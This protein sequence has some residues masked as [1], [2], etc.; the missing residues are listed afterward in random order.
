MHVRIPSDSLPIAM[1]SCATFISAACWEI[2]W[3]DGVLFQES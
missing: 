2:I 1:R 3:Q